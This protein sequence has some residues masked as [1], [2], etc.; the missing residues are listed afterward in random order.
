MGPPLSS[1]SQRISNSIHPTAIVGTEVLLGSDNV[2]GPY[3]VIQGRVRIGDGNWFGPHVTIGTPAQYT[4]EKF[5]FIGERSS[6]ISIGSRCVLREYTTVHQPS[7]HTTMIEDDCYL[8]AYCHVS[9]DTVLRRNVNLAN[10]V[11]IGG[12]TEIQEFATVGLSVAVHQHTTIG[13][14]AMIGMGAVVAKDVPPFSKATG[15][16]ATLRGLNDVGLLRNGF[17]A[18]LVEKIRSA[19]QAGDLEKC[20]EP[21]VAEI[22]RRFAERRASTHRPCMAYEGSRS[23]STGNPAETDSDSA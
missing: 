4:T 15:N 12:F 7:M 11:Q 19:W 2:V 16:P 3:S 23:K 8:M 9:H 18:E 20:D 17:S 22:L 10:N 21:N 14:F 1:R 5:E 6:G 13:A